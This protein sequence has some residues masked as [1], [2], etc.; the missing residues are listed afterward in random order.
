MVIVS[1]WKK[2]LVGKWNWM[3]PL[4][5]LAFIYLALLL[6]ACAFSDHLIHQPPK[7]GYT[8]EAPGVS[9]IAME[10][11]EKIA[12]SY[13]PASRD[14]PTLLWSHGNAED[15]GYLRRRHL[16]LHAEGYGILAYD[17]PGYG[18]SEGSPSEQGCYDASM[19]VWKHLT[20]TLDVSA[21]NVILY[22]QSVGSGASVWLATQVDASGLVLV[23]P[24]VS[25][26][27]T[28]T[29]VPLF[30][31][32][33]FR[34]LSRIGQTHMP[35]LVIHGSEDQ[36]I[37]QWHGKKLYDT[38]PGP[39]MWAGIDGAGHNDIYLLAEDEIMR[40]I[41]DFRSECISRVE[42]PQ[43]L[44]PKKSSITAR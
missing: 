24:F 44:T 39:K 30:P 3:R 1:H 11:G 29:R 43:S 25:A 8:A 18:I 36:V 34:N 42:S 20:E 4:K 14:M 12:V 27:R 15:I 16:S 23:S 17:Y 9:L 37:A 21:E 10:N 5:S 22:G 40:A 7:A 28:V 6:V 13:L 19:A 2:I 33:K 41:K 35:L 38:H 31:G 26:F 32:D